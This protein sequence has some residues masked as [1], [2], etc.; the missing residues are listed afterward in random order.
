MRK[1]HP[2]RTAAEESCR[3][4]VWRLIFISSTESA[5]VDFICTGPVEK[6]G[7]W[8]PVFCSKFKAFS[9]TCL[10]DLQ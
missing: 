9:A 7:R 8:I 6:E 10:T 1:S 2:A 5:M 3:F 4:A